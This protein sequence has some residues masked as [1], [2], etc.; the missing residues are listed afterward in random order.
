MRGRHND[1]CQARHCGSEPIPGQELCDYHLDQEESGTTVYRKIPFDFRVDGEQDP[2]PE[3]VKPFRARRIPQPT[4][5][6]LA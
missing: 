5:R 3:N 4:V 1:L 6:R 2:E